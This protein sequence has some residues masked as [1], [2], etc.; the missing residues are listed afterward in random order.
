[1]NRF[2]FVIACLG[3]LSI[4]SAANAQ[5]VKENI[6]VAHPADALSAS[7]NQK[8]EKAGL[9]KKYV[10]IEKYDPLRNADQDIQDALTEAKRTNRRVLLEV[11]GLWCVW[12]RHMD[13]FFDKHSDVLALREKYFVTLKINFSDE[14][15]NEVVLSRYP[16]VAGFPHIFVLDNDGNLL[17]SQDT[18]ELE[19]GKGYNTDKFTEFLKQ[20]A[21]VSAITVEK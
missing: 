18:G 8:A 21:D 9:G 14:N 7:D 5:A 19:E 3:V 13:D 1:M 15:K 20:W 11:G 12:C 4:S 2:V 17:H 6:A 10:P 16:K